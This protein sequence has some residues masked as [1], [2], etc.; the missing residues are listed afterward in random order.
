[1]RA[2]LG[3]EAVFGNA[4]PLDGTA[5][6]KVLGDDFF[7]VFGTDIAV[8]HGLGIDNHV[9]AVL[10]LI[11]AAGLVDAHAAGQAR[12]PGELL[13]ARVQFAFAV[14]AAGGTRRF[15]RTDIMADKDVAFETGQGQSSSRAGIM[16]E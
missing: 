3:I 7:G 2:G 13:Q 14:L 10:A 11:Q 4:Q 16:P 9:G 5:A 12:F 15:R 6:D 8:P 1:M